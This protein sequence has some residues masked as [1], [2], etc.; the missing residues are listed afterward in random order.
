MAGE[1]GPGRQ[2][3]GVS[4]GGSAGKEPELKSAPWEGRLRLQSQ[5]ALGAPEAKDSGISS[6]PGPGK[7]KGREPR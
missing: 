7:L 3:P 4:P 5:P 1:A 6:A 2:V